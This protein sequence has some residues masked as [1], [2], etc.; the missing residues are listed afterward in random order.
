MIVSVIMGLIGVLAASYTVFIDASLSWI[1]LLIAFTAVSIQFLIQRAWT[2][3]IDQRT[4]DEREEVTSAIRQSAAEG[5]DTESLVSAAESA[6][7]GTSKQ[8]NF[9]VRRLAYVTQLDQSDIMGSADEIAME[10]L[11]S[12]PRAAKRLMNQLRM[13]VVVAMG[14]GLFGPMD[15]HKL[16][17]QLLAKLCVLRERWPELA[18]RVDADSTLLD[19]FEKPESSDLDPANNERTKHMFDGVEDDDEARRLLHERPYFG[20][21]WS[22]LASLVSTSPTENSKVFQPTMG[23]DKNSVTPQ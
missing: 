17:S 2:R 8:T 1:G 11:P 6:W 16:I 5:S 21:R 13:L 7:A 10:F 19:L 4:R 23:L 15:D 14:R 3:R 22:E 20:H 18:K 12:R 9:D